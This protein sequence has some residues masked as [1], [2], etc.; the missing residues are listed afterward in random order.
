MREPRSLPSVVSPST[1]IEH[2]LKQ[3]MTYFETDRKAA[4]RCL[5]DASTLLGGDVENSPVSVPGLKSVRRAGLAKWQA[6]QTLAYIEANLTSKIGIG[7]L[8]KVVSLSKSHFC[9]TFRESLGLPPMVYVAVRRVERAKALLC[10][11]T[12]PIAEIALACGFADQSHFS[13]RFR[14]LV[15]MTPGRWRRSNLA[16][17]ESTPY[18]T[19]R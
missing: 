18:S 1:W 7:D 2:L 16:G 15:G 11:T 12:E 6:R 4:W 14:D 13:R 9:R 19:G 5:R 3:A 10:S 17:P 8:A